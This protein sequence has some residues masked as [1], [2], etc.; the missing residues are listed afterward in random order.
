MC[1]WLFCLLVALTFSTIDSS[2]E[3]VR[4][5]EPIEFEFCKGIGYNYSGMPNFFNHETQEDARQNYLTFVPLIKYSCSSQ[6]VFF[7][8]SVYVPMCT[9]KVPFPIGP[10]R[11][12]CESVR[13]SCEP[14]L[15][16]FGFSWPEQMNCT[17]FPKEN[18]DTEMCMKGPSVES[19]EAAATPAPPRKGP[20]RPSSR[21][22]IHAKQSTNQCLQYRYGD[23]HYVFINSSQRCGQVC[24]R[25]VLFSSENKRFAEIWIAV[26]SVAAFMTSAFTV[27][28]YVMDASRY[29]NPDRAIVYLCACYCLQSIGY[30]IRLLLGRETASCHSE[31]Q[32]SVLVHQDLSNSYCTAVF[33]F[34]YYFTNA[35][36]MW[37]V[38]VTITWFMSRPS[39]YT[40]E[41]VRRRMLALHVAAWLLPALMTAAILIMRAVDAEELTGVCYVGNQNR[42]T[43]LAFVILPHIACLCLGA[44]FLVSGALKNYRHRNRKPYK[45]M[46]EDSGSR[47]WIFAILY[48]I[49]ACGV[50]GVNI[51]EYLNRDSWTLNQS[52]RSAGPYVECFSFKFFMSVIVGISAGLWTWCSKG[53]R[54]P[55]PAIQKP[56]AAPPLLVSTPFQHQ[57]IMVQNQYFVPQR[58]V[59]QMQ[60]QQ[61]QQHHHTLQSLHHSHHPQHHMQTLQH[62]HSP[63]ATIL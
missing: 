38:V 16:S 40:A 55:D 31:G 10:C 11:P 36:A 18:S 29:D 39:Q 30:F 57:P 42:D 28:L 43:L 15:N 56:G 51:Y 13:S 46:P 25:D 9:D 63:P 22:P 3:V 34:I 41:Q 8:C 50:L 52:V 61:Q 37:W 17:N 20:K 1:S 7:L 54:L 59:H 6:L 49:P 60:Q 45:E 53:S 24:D 47:T 32:A 33:V 48:F 19:A 58:M 14:T 44:A 35:A 27:L 12:L 62:H 4:T 5:C 21:K 2:A 23:R 26:W